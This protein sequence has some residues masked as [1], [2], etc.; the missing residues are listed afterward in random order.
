MLLYLYK[1]I[2]IAIFALIGYSHPLSRALPGNWEVS[3]GRLSHSHFHCL[4]LK[5]KKPN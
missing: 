1:L 4:S 3:S 2:F 5:S